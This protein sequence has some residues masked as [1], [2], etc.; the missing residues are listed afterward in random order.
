MVTPGSTAPLSSLTRPFSCAV[1]CAQ[2]VPPMRSRPNATIAPRVRKPLM[3]L[4]LPLIRLAAPRDQLSE[5]E[6]RADAGEAPCEHGQ[7][8]LPWPARHEHIVVGKDGAG[9]HHVVEIDA[10]RRPR[11]T[12]PQDLG[13]TEIELV[14]PIP[15]HRP[16]RDQVEGHVRHVS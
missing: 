8:L 9:V 5:H 15:V 12:R 14:E 10:D 16:R 4:S 1:A 13:D 2:A 7:W 3:T 11:A 6:L